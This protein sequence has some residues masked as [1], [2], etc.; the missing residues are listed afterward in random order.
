MT[1]DDTN[2]L[3]RSRLATVVLLFLG[4]VAIVRASIGEESERQINIAGEN[5]TVSTG[6]PIPVLTQD[7]MPATA[8]GVV[9][10]HV[11]FTAVFSNAP[12]AVFQWEKISGGVAFDV[13]GATNSTLTLTNLQL[14]DTAS[15]WLK[16]ASA[17]NRHAI[18]YTS[19]R[20]LVVYR[21][22]A[23]TNNIVTVVAAQ[24]A[25]SS[26][27]AFMPTWSFATNNS[28]LA[29]RPRN[30]PRSND[31]NF[32]GSWIWDTNTFDQQTC[33]FWKTFDIPPNKR[34]R[35]AMLIM[36]ADNE[37]TLFLDGQL[38]GHVAEWREYWEYDVTLMMTPGR[39]VLAVKAYN[40]S[41]VAGMIF[42]LHVDLEDGDTIEIKSDPS[43][44]VVPQKTWHWETR[45]LAPSTWR[46]ATIVGELGQPPW[47]L[48]PEVLKAGPPLQPVKVFFWQTPWFQIMFSILFGLFLLTIF[49]LAAQLALHQR[50][51]WL[52]QRERARIAM[53]IHDDIGSR[54]TQLVLNG[55]VAKEYLPQ[56]SRVR[57]QLG[58]ICDDARR[59]LSSIDEILWALNPRLDTLQD[60]ADYICDYAH[61]Y[62]E[63]SAIECVFEV[64]PKMSLIEADLPLR[65][66][67][68]MAIKETLNNIV[69]H[70]S[71]TELRL[72]I[73]RQRQ[74]VVLVVQD[75][76]KGFDPAAITPG[77]NGLSNMSRRMRELGGSCHI[78]SQPGKGCHIE[79]F[80]PL[81][82]PRKFLLGK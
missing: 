70:S 47:G 25:L 15:Y 64:D 49:F 27:P 72:K 3:R 82:R 26:R 33:C 80:I 10:G 5:P 57:V 19:A 41:A 29:E 4:I 78:S 37:Y 2:L 44:K 24:A 22:P 55:E 36:S 9:G 58:R 67:L 56:D 68:L 11:T 30:P 13:P 14:S 59:V 20:L 62:L 50:E 23:E 39:H 53:D 79:F 81:K 73:E 28:L 71:A 16:A 60:F 43:W 48:T 42:G 32:L 12:A 52:L 51:R 6:P 18:T 65:R 77:R 75:N 1:L 17:S 21:T 74:H 38:I 66:S 40:S 8:F 35:N 46:P 69:K 31:L 34:V 54:I 7:T 76:G 45:K 63:P 61:N